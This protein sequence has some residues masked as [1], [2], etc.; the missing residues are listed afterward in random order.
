MENNTLYVGVH[1][2]FIDDKAYFKLDTTKGI[3][4][5]DIQSVL[6]G[7]LNLTIRCEDSEEEQFKKLK[8]ITRH[9]ESEL[10]N[11]SSFKDLHNGIKKD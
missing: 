2:E 8:Q 5:V 11:D 10:F 6:V 9:M 7:G 1:V 4:L 3:S